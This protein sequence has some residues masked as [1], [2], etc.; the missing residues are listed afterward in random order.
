MSIVQ[1][2]SNYNNSKIEYLDLA[3]T[4][5]FSIIDNT[6]LIESTDNNNNNNNNNNTTNST[7]TRQNN[8]N[9]ENHENIVFS[10]TSIESIYQI[11]QQIVNV[12]QCSKLLV[13][14]VSK[15]QLGDEF[16]IL[17]ANELR[18]NKTLQKLKDPVE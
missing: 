5:Q 17:I 3:Q 18:T 12:L 13:L 11:G 7:P 14:D 8:N 16:A 2:L 1:A 10:E 4:I 15:N 9:N 6:N